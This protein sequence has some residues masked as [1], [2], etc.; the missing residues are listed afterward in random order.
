MVD[1]GANIGYFCHIWLAAKADNRVVAF[2]ASP[3]VF[4]ILVRNIQ[5]H[6]GWSSRVTLHELAAT[7]K[8]ENLLFDV[9]PPEQT[10][11]GGIASKDSS[12]HLVEVQAVRL[13]EI[14]P[15]NTKVDFLKV[16]VEGADP[17][18]IL[19][20]EGLLRNHSIRAGSFE[21]NNVRQLK[22]G[23]NSDAAVKLLEDCGY[24]VDRYEEDCTF[25]LPD[26]L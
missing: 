18:V 10:G 22:L 23:V 11:W 25:R 19:G 21:I 9:G 6:V 7:N 24:I 5:A 2:E 26:N 14:L 20:A 17:L 1:V 15:P 13:D 12:G 3:R 16:D 4:P 8:N